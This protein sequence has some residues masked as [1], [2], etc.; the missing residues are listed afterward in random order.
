LAAFST[1]LMVLFIFLSCP[2][3]ASAQGFDC[4]A[5]RNYPGL[6]PEGYAEAC[7]ETGNPPE[8]PPGT[9][10][11]PKDRAFAHDLRN[12]RNTVTHPHDD[13]SD[14]SVIGLSTSIVFGYDYN[15]DLSVLYGIN[16]G[17]GQLGTSDG[18]TFVPIGLPTRPEGHTWSGLAIDPVSGEAYL[19]S[20]NSTFST[21]QS[22][23]LETGLSTFIGNF[24]NLELVIEISINCDGVMYAHDIGTDAIYTIDRN[25][26]TPTLVGAHGL[27]TNF[28]Q[29]MDFDNDSGDLYIYAYTGG[30]SVT[31]G[32]VNL[33]DGSITPLN[34]NDPEGEWEGASQTT[35]PPTG[36]A[37]FEVIKD[38]DD[39]N[40]VGVE[41]SI[42]CNTG[43]PLMQSRTIN[44]GDGV[45]FVV[46][47]FLNEELNCE[48]TENVPM[49]YSPNYFNGQMSSP[50]GCVFENIEPGS[51][52]TCEI[53]N[54]LNRVDVVATK[55]W[56]DDNPQF[57]STNQAEAAWHCDNVAFECDGS[58]AGNCYS[59]R[60][61]FIGNPASDIFSVFPDWD[62]GTECRVSELMISDGNVESDDSDCGSII[63]RPG[64]GAA[65]TIYN[66][67]LYAGIPILD[68]TGLAL[69]CLLIF[70]IGL[71]AFRRLV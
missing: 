59:G 47:D 35:C 21:L 38:F 48:I 56:V 25:N 15:P 62:G 5:Y 54:S 31:Y 42:E 20:T 19:S 23:D 4:S 14:F 70:S 27:E 66:T 9:P 43:L 69:L 39:D 55:Q 33:N 71:L 29:G 18:V 45:T 16:W 64:A 8:A 44:E 52:L 67:R 37:R 24:G 3:T 49:G 12:T 2:L 51:G 30:G 10:N 41:V 26:G 1:F 17:T 40:P 34:V 32:R 13:L 36:P 63:L 53:T 28:A 60:L 11:A 46:D 58:I 57:E 6:E 68:R 61:E 50:T 7:I 65:C 22:V